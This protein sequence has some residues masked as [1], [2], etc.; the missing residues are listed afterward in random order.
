MVFTDRLLSD[1]PELLALAIFLVAAM[2]TRW[3][4]QR[5]P[6][7]R[8]VVRIFAF[9]AFTYFL[10]QA[11]Q[12]PYLVARP[13]TDPL[14]RFLGDSLKAIWWFW[15]AAI[16]SDLLRTF[17]FRG[18]QLAG[19]R[20]FRDLGVAG[21]YLCGLIGLI[22][23]VLNLP[24]QGILVTSGAVAVAIGLALQSSLADVIYGI[25][26]SL[27]KPYSAGDWISLDNGAEGK[28]IEMNW[29]ATHLL[30]DHRD[31]VIVPNSVI[32]K[33]KIINASFPY[34]VHG[35]TITVP[36][37]RSGAVPGSVPLRVARLGRQ[38][39]PLLMYLSGGP[40]GAGV[41]EMLGVMAELPE[42]PSRFTVIGF[43]QR[44]T[45]RSGLIR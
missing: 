45:G 16:C 12:V 15:A 17:A 24:V 7:T 38:G 6:V 34:R 27:G 23:F 4:F 25:V 2:A 8:R 20:L 42:L 14:A 37:D 32:A 33:A 13:V 10:F 5:L 9:L 22:T 39:G 36:L 44:G 35:T 31:V 1:R 41:S 30:T 11:N 3:G 29:R 21:I 28:I 43:D 19:H 40:G 26:L 18:S